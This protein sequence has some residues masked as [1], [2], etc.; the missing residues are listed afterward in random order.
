MSAKNTLIAVF[1][2][3][4]QQYGWAISE[5]RFAPKQDILVEDDEDDDDVYLIRSGKATVIIGGGSEIILGKGDLIGE[6]SFLLSNKRTASI[7]AKDAVHCWSVSVSN[8][9]K[10]FQQDPP[11]AARFYKAL[12]G[13]LALRLVNSS[14]RATQ[15]QVFQENDDALIS[16]MEIQASELQDQLQNYVR[17]LMNDAVVDIDRVKKTVGQLDVERTGDFKERRTQINRL[18]S[19][20]RQ[21]QSRHFEKARPRLKQF[22][23]EIQQ[24]LMEILDLEKR[25]E[26]GGRAFEIFSR[27]ILG[28][29]PFLKLRTDQSL[30]AVDVMLHI[31]HRGTQSEIWSPKDLILDWIDRVLW[32]MPTFDA[33]RARHDLTADVINQY[34][35]VEGEAL[36]ITLI[37][38]SIGVVLAKVVN[39]AARTQSHVNMVYTDPKT[40]Y[41][42]QFALTGRMGHVDINTHRLPSLLSTVI[43][44]ASLLPNDVPLHSQNLI[45]ISGLINYLPDRYLVQLLSRA[46]QF[47]SP[48]GSILLSGILPTEDQALFNDF[49]Q[50]PMIRRSDEEL[51]RLLMSLGFAVDVHIRKN[52]VVVQ[53]KTRRSGL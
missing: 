2:D 31:F 34:M 3:I 18:T 6:M 7:V 21:I 53:A 28:E 9:E 46:E 42:I 4:H 44:E 40:V 51:S 38:D 35:S 48:T 50:W 43:G 25:N 10:V 11:L 37:Y 29:V 17:I 12:G 41:Q 5:H 39:T 26:V 24:M 8:M 33:F 16:L 32:E 52:S 1:E 13:L 23:N 47:L 14:K 30:E 27:S 22:F 15:N 45:V 36:N 49:F 19:E 20:L